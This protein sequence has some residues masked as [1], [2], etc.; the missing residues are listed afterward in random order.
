MKVY[1]RSYKIQTVLIVMGAIM[2]TASTLEWSVRNTD[3]LWI[4]GLFCLGLGIASWFAMQV[5]RIRR[6]AEMKKRREALRAQKAQQGSSGVKTPIR[7][8]L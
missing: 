2:C 5:D 4:L 8:G 3:W 7:R 1:M 6:E